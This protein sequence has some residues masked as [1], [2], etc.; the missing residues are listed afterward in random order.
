MSRLRAGWLV[1]RGVTLEAW[2][3]RHDLEPYTRECDTCG[4]PRTCSIPFAVGQLRGLF[5]PP[6]A[7]GD[8]EP[9][10]Y[11]LVRAAKHGDLFGGDGRIG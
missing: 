7:C 5:S 1:V 8:A 10:P 11:C 6:C 3:K 2:C 9:T 4:Q